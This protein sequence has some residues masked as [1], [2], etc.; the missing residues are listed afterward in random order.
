MI[1]KRFMIFTF[2]ALSYLFSWSQPF[3]SPF[4]TTTTFNNL[5]IIADGLNT[6]SIFSNRDTTL[7]THDYKI[8]ISSLSGDKYFLRSET[9]SSKIYQYIDEREYLV[10]DL[11]LSLGD[12]FNIYYRPEITVDEIVVDSVFTINNKKH[13]RF[14]FL[15]NA[16]ANEKLEFIEGVGTNIGLFYQH[17]FLSEFD[18]RWY[19][20]C[21]YKD[22]INNYKNQSEIFKD[23]CNV[24]ELLK[25]NLINKPHD[26]SLFPNPVKDLLN[27]KISNSCSDKYII[28]LIDFNGRQILSQ[29]YFANEI[30]I[31]ISNLSKGVYLLKIRD[32]NNN[33][34]CLK[35]VKK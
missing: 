21:S 35:F 25:I 2:S 23:K 13:I 31:N 16:I 15:V 10:M 34:R 6:D 22:G 28:D 20:L 26:V 17:C 18:Q 4:G 33:L 29:Q 14:N 24:N 8:F 9:D 3:E 7:L 5:R 32:E 1:M 11:N 12:T 27:V 30:Q 19:L